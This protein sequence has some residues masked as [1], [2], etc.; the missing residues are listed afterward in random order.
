MT[1]NT[2]LFIFHNFQCSM[3]PLFHITSRRR[4][5]IRNLIICYRFSLLFVCSYYYFFPTYYLF[6]MNIYISCTAGHMRSRNVK[7]TQMDPIQKMELVYDS[8]SYVTNGFNMNERETDAHNTP[9]LRQKAFDVPAHKFNKKRKNSDLTASPPSPTVTIAANILQS[10]ES[11]PNS[12][13]KKRAII[14]TAAATTTTTAAMVATTTTAP[15]MDFLSATDTTDIGE[16]IMND[17]YHFLL[18]LQPFM[19]ELSPIQ[20]LRL[21]MKI[22]TLVFEEL[23]ANENDE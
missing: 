21:R 4:S 16:R 10:L 8:F 9:A 22:Q 13:S 12:L 1:L 11:N 18:S 20:K 6:I 19:S 15:S 3:Q 23:Y 14:N 17:D 2:N 7:C 5:L